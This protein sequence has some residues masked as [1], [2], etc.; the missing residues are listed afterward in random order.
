ME[1]RFLT[2]MRSKNRIQM[3][4]NL[5]GILQPIIQLNAIHP[6]IHRQALS[7]IQIRF[8]EHIY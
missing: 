7:M 4:L 8:Y 5:A 1:Y 6:A 3:L 2:F